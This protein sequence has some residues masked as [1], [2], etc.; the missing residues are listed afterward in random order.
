MAMIVRM[1]F[2]VVESE[3]ISDEPWASKLA[4][5]SL[6]QVQVMEAIQVHNNVAKETNA[7]LRVIKENT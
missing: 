1:N 2:D 3:F 4:L 5:K 7:V 6:T